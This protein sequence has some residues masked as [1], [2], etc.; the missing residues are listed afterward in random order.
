M[1]AVTANSDHVVVV[2]AADASVRG[3]GSEQGA[4]RLG[5]RGSKLT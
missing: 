4:C 3:D 2:V 5:L 1:R